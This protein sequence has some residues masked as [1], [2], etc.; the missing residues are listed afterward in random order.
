MC[1]LI[2]S[3]Q[4][5]RVSVPTKSAEPINPS[6]K[7]DTHSPVGNKPQTETLKGAK[8]IDA[9]PAGKKSLGQKEVIPFEWKLIGDAE[10]Y[11]L[12]LFKAIEREEVEAQFE[13]VQK[14]GYYK[15][16]KILTNNA[17]VAQSKTT[18]KTKKAVESLKTKT[19]TLAASKFGKTTGTDSIVRISFKERDKKKAKEEKKKTKKTKAKAKKSTVKKKAA[20]K[21]TKK[22]TSKKK[23]TKKKTDKKKSPQKTSKLA[24]ATKKP[25]AVSRKKVKKSAKKKKK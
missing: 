21:T 24:K 8:A 25:K 11:S 9:I 23:T 6:A 3:I 19:K 4:I 2:P 1:F 22:K 15:N 16:L 12:T 5:S 14:E 13:R 7:V 17:K 18:K 10:G 20:K